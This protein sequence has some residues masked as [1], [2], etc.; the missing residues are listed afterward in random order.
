MSEIRD[1]LK[2]G[3]EDPAVAQAAFKRALDDI[4]AT[5]EQA[6]RYASYESALASKIIELRDR[7]YGGPYNSSHPEIVALRARFGL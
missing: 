3:V 6:E 1:L 2:M 7:G 5:E 4:T